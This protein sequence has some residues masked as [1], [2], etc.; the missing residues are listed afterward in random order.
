MIERI[1]QKQQERMWLMKTKTAKIVCTLAVCVLVAGTVSAR[2]HHHHRGSKDLHRAAAIVDIVTN[3]LVSL[4]VLS[5]NTPVVAP[6]PVV[7]TPTPVV[8][9][10]PVVVAPTPV[11]APAPVVVA[12]APVYVAPPPP[13]RPVYVAPPRRYYRPA[14]PPPRHHHAPAH[15]GGGHKGG[16]R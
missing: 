1:H 14:P 9:P 5:G 2:S 6:A 7:V 12:P 16:R 13:P 3:S 10:A 8:A 15:R 11:V 4:S